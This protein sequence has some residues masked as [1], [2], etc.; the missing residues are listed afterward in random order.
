MHLPS[1]PSHHCMCRRIDDGE[2]AGLTANETFGALYLDMDGFNGINDR[3]GRHAGDEVLR[4]AANRI[5]T[6][7]VAGV[8][9]ARTRPTRLPFPHR[10]DR[11]LPSRAT[12]RLLRASRYRASPCRAGLR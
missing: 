8:F 10:H 11:K 9:N 3:L 12:G 2:T 5:R 1:A 6:A 7:R 4:E